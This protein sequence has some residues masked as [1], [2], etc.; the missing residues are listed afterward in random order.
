MHQRRWEPNA[1][2]A[3]V[4]PMAIRFQAH[5]CCCSHQSLAHAYLFAGAGGTLQRSALAPPLHL[6]ARN[7]HASVVKL[8]LKAGAEPGSRAPNGGTA[9]HC[10]VQ[11]G[12]LG[13]VELLLEVDPSLVSA[14][15]ASGVTPLD[16]VPP[17]TLLFKV[18]EGL[19]AAA[20]GP[21]PPGTAGP[22]KAGM[23]GLQLGNATSL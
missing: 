3:V 13:S 12:H 17:D 4:W 5:V 9:L 1:P 2:A 18:L 6:A 21:P 22:S 8:L 7:G 15:D 10:A 20:A 14:A 16:C 23:A 19:F 11:S